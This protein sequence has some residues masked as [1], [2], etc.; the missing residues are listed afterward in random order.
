MQ[1]HRVG[2][3]CSQ[4]AG[5]PLK[6]GSHRNVCRLGGAPV[7][8]AIAQ[9]PTAVPFLSNADHL[10]EWGPQSWKNFV[11]LQQPNYPDVV[12]FLQRCTPGSQFGSCTC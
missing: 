3:G 7:T 6:A 12:S 2:L 1:V 4:L 5:R 11:A 9:P 10:E 8:R